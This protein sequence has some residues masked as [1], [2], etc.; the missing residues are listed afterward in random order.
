MGGAKY[1]WPSH[2]AFSTF[3]NIRFNFLYENEPGD[4]IKIKGV[5]DSPS[6]RLVGITGNYPIDIYYPINT[7]F[8][9]MNKENISV[10]SLYEYQLDHR[11]NK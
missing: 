5:T 10:P 3:W 2:A 7:Y 9:G 4:T 6:E 1:W 8:E 11:K